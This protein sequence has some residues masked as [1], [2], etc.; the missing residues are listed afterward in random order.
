M[1][2]HLPFLC[3]PA[4]DGARARNS[5]TP[6]ALEPLPHHR[7]YM[8]GWSFSCVRESRDSFKPRFAFHQWNKG[9]IFE[10]RSWKSTHLNELNV[11]KPMV[12]SILFH[13]E[14][15]SWDSTTWFRIWQI[16]TPAWKWHLQMHLLAERFVFG[17]WWSRLLERGSQDLSNGT[18]DTIRFFFLHIYSLWASPLLPAIFDL[19][20][21]MRACME[22]N[23]ETHQSGAGSI[24][25]SGRRLSPQ[26]CAE[27]H[28]YSTVL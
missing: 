1:V 16:Q 22:K 12:V 27:H 21:S 13:N 25:G 11:K 18:N 4:F 9:L 23:R 2:L 5:S 24:R 20:T 17:G 7:L 3:S 28:K 8:W 10:I 14:V 19:F 26:F 15:K 6:I